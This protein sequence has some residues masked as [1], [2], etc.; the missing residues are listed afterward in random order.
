MS[1]NY[2]QTVTPETPAVQPAPVVTE[3]PV[4]PP[5]QVPPAPTKPARQPLSAWEQVM[6][7]LLLLGSII[8]VDFALFGDF[9]LGYTISMFLNVILYFIFA[10]KGKTTLYGILCVLS[11]L[12]GSVVFALYNDGLL[13][14]GLFCLNIVLLAAAISQRFG[15]QHYNS[16][17]FR[18]V[19]DILYVIFA[20]PFRYIGRA[21]GAL[22]C[23]REGKKISSGVV[24]GVLCAIPVLLIVTPLLIRADEAF[25]K[26]FS[27]FNAENFFRLFFATIIGIGLFIFYYAHAYGMRYDLFT[28]RPVARKQGKSLPTAALMAFLGCISLVYVLYLV[29]QITYFFSAFWGEMPADFLPAAYAR[30]GFF[31]MCVIS[32]INLTLVFFV[33]LFSKREGG[34]VGLPLGCVCTFISLFSLLLIA[35]ALAKMLLYVDRFGLTRMRIQTSAFMIFLSV[36][37]IVLILRLLITRLPYMRLILLSAAIIT[38]SLGFMDIDATIARHN[39][40]AYQSGQLSTIDMDELVYLDHSALPYIAELMEDEDAD[41]AARA[42]EIVEDTACYDFNMTRY[43]NTLPAYEFDIRDFNLSEYKAYQTVQRVKDQL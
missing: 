20:C 21:M 12:A 13:L 37:F 22:F 16:G 23:R 36:V 38:V 5:I 8:S 3:P 33:L 35:T 24:I 32:V 27:F 19:T 10:G 1:E 29:S 18:T 14:F 4:T 42:K 9:N 11:A 30:R 31:E 34:K 28:R 41:I 15:V 17:S 2:Y 40:H 7:I 43:G 39:I 25:A 26:M 6:T